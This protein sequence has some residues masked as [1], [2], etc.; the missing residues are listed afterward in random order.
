[1]ITTDSKRS[2]LI[3]ISDSGLARDV[4]VGREG[5][6]LREIILTIHGTFFLWPQHRS[7]LPLMFAMLELRQT[8]ADT[9]D[10]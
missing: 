7:L 5:E 2:R 8:P 1:V 3:D 9:A 6:A 4:T 10:T